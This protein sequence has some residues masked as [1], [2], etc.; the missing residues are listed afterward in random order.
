A[1][2]L[3]SRLE[4]QRQKVGVVSGSGKEQV[5]AQEAQIERLKAVVAFR[6]KQV[7]SM[8][9]RSIEKGVLAEL[10]LELG[11][12]VTPGQ[13]LAKVVQPEKLKATLRIPETQARDVVLGLLASIDT[14]NGVVQGTVSRISPAASQGAVEVDVALPAELPKGARP[15]LTV[16]GTVTIENLANVLH[17]GRPAGA[18]ENSAVELFK[19]NGDEAHRVRVKL[20]RSSVTTIEV[21]EGLQEGDS[22]ILS[23]MSAWS[24]AERVRLR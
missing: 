23:D 21:L 2:E 11:Q 22:V 4:L 24:E 18:Q 13:L 10:P 19:V 7:E 8:K 5:A 9:V 15:D 3:H 14:R 16:E 6:R 20:G 17:V 1:R 12:W